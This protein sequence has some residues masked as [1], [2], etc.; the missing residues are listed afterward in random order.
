MPTKVCIV[1]AMVFP[2]VMH[3]CE[4]WTI[5][6]AEHLEL[7]VSSW[8]AEE[9]SWES[10][11]LKGDQTSQFYRK[12]TLNIHWKDWYWSWS[13]S[14]SATWCKELSHWK[15]PDAGKDCKRR[16]GRQM[17][18]WLDSITDSMDVNVSKLRETV[19]DREA[20][21]AVVHGV[22]KSWTLLSNRTTT[23]NADR[24]KYVE[25]GIWNVLLSA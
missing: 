14:T 2:V 9:D 20:W 13:S 3:R 15:R 7:M 25:F 17:I 16:T 1:K 21:C 10:L 12:S 24:S 22:T 6:K 23:N 11:G 5:K 8:D 19:K 4:S 18:R